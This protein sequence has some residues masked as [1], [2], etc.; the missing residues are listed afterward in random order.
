M[1]R[2]AMRPAR[3]LVRLLAVAICAA[4]VAVPAVHAAR[5][6]QSF[7]N[8]ADAARKIQMQLNK[9]ADY[10][11]VKVRVYSPEKLTIK[12]SIY[13]GADFGWRRIFGNVRKVSTYRYMMVL[14]VAGMPI[15]PT[16]GFEDT[17]F[18]L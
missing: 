13:I 7:T 10:R 17:K 3:A 18:P 9:R 6:A 8:P 11:S 12:G 16:A 1:L 14:Q 5:N 4:T 2:P 15:K